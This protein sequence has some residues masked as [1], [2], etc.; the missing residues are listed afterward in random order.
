MIFFIIVL[1]I[2]L[3]NFSSTVGFEVLEHTLTPRVKATQLCISHLGEAAD[4][5]YDVTIAYGNTLSQDE[6]GHSHRVSSPGL[7]G[8]ILIL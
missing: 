2:R 8:K 6:L 1:V 5:I 7:A 4:A 3:N